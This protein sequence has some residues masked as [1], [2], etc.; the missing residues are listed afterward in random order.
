MISSIKSFKLDYLQCGFRAR[1]FEASVFFKGL[2]GFTWCYVSV[3][4]PC[5]G[6]NNINPDSVVYSLG[7]FNY[8]CLSIWYFSLD[9]FLWLK[10]YSWKLK[11]KNQD[12]PIW[13]EQSPYKPGLFKAKLWEPSPVDPPRV[14]PACAK[15]TY[16]MHVNFLGY[17]QLWKYQVCI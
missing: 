3:G 11:K 13:F 4:H 15:P 1:Q 12:H 6:I 2:R 8:L 7:D 5:A 16:H 17:T 10:F 9:F 14:S